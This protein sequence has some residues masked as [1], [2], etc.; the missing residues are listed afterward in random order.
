MRPV[1]A[2]GALGALGALDAGAGAGAAAAGVGVEADA[3]ARDARVER[4]EGAGAAA[5]A[6]VGAGSGSR[7]GAALD[8]GLRRLNL[9][10]SSLSGC[11]GGAGAARFSWAAGAGVSARR[12]R[13]RV[14]GPLNSSG[15]GLN[16]TDFRRLGA[17]S[18]SCRLAWLTQ[19][20]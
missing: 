5:G 7:L 2:T 6:G 3:A 8:A 14:D 17:M 10:P 16:D 20:S 11:A 1:D 13:R 15:L 4:E 9:K 12:L 19:V 18:A